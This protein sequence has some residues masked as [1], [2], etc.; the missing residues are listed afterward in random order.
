MW[1]SRRVV[2]SGALVA[3]AIAAVIGA[4]LP[5][6]VWLRSFSRTNPVDVTAAA[7]WVRPVSGG[8]AVIA[9]LVLLSDRL[10]RIV[11]SRGC[12][13]AFP[14]ICIVLFIWFKRSAGRENAVYLWAAREDSIIEYATALSFFIAVPVSVYVARYAARLHLRLAA[15][16][17]LALAAVMTVMGLEE[18]SYGQRIFGF[19]TPPTIAQDN[20]QGEFNFHNLASMKWLADNVAPTIIIYWGVFGFLGIMLSRILFSNR[21]K[22]YDTAKLMLPP[23]YLLTFFLPLPLWAD[24]SWWGYAVWQDQEI[25]EM[26]LG[27]AFLLF[28]LNS[29]QGV[30]QSSAARS[31]PFLKGRVT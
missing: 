1:K 3:V 23:W 16:F 20:T 21:S 4:A 28:S 30:G 10:K 29:L 15:L 8:V 22:W 5:V 11:F 6:S 2:V 17:H 7:N 9:M 19:E 12:L 25:A 27:M 26:F 14:L 13:F 18:I 31:E 24:H